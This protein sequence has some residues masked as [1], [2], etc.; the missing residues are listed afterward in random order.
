MSNNN[1]LSELLFDFFY[2]QNEVLELKYIQDRLTNIKSITDLHAIDNNQ[3]DPLWKVVPQ[4]LMY[5]FGLEAFKS[6]KIAHFVSK[7]FLFIHPINIHLVEKLKDDVSSF[8]CLGEEKD[9]TFSPSIASALYGGY[10]WHNAYVAASK[11]LC[12]FGKQSKLIIIENMNRKKNDCIIEYKNNHRNKIAEPIT[13]EQ[14]ILGTEMDGIINSFHSPDYIEN[15]R[16][17]VNLGLITLD[18]VCND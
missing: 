14:K 2:A 10:K 8:L 17:M 15:K 13:I 3:G 11:H 6:F 16:Q 7:S 4:I 5:R 1:Q 9:I 12:S 18:G